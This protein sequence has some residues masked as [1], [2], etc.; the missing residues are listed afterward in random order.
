MRIPKHIPN[1]LKRL[2]N[3][4]V[5]NGLTDIIEIHGASPGMAPE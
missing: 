5:K 2:V 4:I 1:E 3:A